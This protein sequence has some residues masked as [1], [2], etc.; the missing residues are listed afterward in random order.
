MET[1]SDADARRHVCADEFDKK[2]CPPSSSPPFFFSSLLAPV[3]LAHRRQKTQEG[4]H[5]A[6]NEQPPACQ[7]T[8]V[9][10]EE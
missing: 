5:E 7:P 9:E 4:N 6:E 10:E 1:M 3:K 2:K 8:G